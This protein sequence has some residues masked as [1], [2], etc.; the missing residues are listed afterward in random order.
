[1]QVKYGEKDLGKCRKK[2]LLLN[3]EKQLITRTNTTTRQTND[4]KS[5]LAVMYRCV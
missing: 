2:T 3:R 4:Q 5:P 1:M